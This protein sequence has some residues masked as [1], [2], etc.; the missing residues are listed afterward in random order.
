[1]IYL[2]ILYFFLDRTGFFFT[3][4]ILNEFSSG[5]VHIPP[6]HLLQMTKCFSASHSSYQHKLEQWHSDFD[7]YNTEKYSIHNGIILK[8]TACTTRPVTGTG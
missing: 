7:W 8:N 6:C 4:L 1:M 5:K 3:S 2:G